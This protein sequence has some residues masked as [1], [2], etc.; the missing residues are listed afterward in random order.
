MG[1]SLAAAVAASE[2][3]RPDQGAGDERSEAGAW[4]VLLVDQISLH[5]DH[6]QALLALW[7]RDPLR[8]VAS[9][10]ADTVGVPALLP[11]HW[12]S[13]LLQL[14]ADE[15]ARAWLRKETALRSIAAPELAV[16]LDHPDQLGL[17]R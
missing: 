8:P 3:A 14:S 10:Y 2:L 11:W 9:R 16:D 6:L 12:R 15:G 7:R 13:R 5:A 4:L 17:L 1:C